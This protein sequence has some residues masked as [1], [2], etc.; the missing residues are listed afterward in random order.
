MRTIFQALLGS[1]RHYTVMGYIVFKLQQP[2]LAG[3]GIQTL[4]RASLTELAKQQPWKDEMPP[5]EKMPEGGVM[6]FPGNLK[7]SSRTES[8]WSFMVVPGRDDL[9]K[10][11]VHA[12]EKFMADLARLVPTSSFR[13]VVSVRTI[14]QTWKVDEFKRN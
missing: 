5:L 8:E 2:C 13:N 14:V 1:E 10:G 12:F 9:R 7:S 11:Q 6:I 3:N 4:L